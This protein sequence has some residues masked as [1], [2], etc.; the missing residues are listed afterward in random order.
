MVPRVGL[1]L[2][3]DLIAAYFPPFAPGVWTEPNAMALRRHAAI[4][5][6]YPPQ[7]NTQV[8]NTSAEN[9]PKEI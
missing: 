6:H 7:R 9:F 2:A 5:S 8:L 3:Q 4:G 1:G